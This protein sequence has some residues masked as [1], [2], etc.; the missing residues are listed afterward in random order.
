M[1][2]SF[3]RAALYITLISLVLTGCGDSINSANETPATATVVAVAAEPT[4]VPTPTEAVPT[5]T[6]EPTQAAP[7]VEPTAEPT[8][9]NTPPPAEPSPTTAPVESEALVRTFHLVP[10]SS[11]ASYSVEE[12]FF[13]QAVNFFN[14][15]GTTQAIEGE[16]TV[17]VERNQVTLGDNRFVVDLRTL[18]SDNSRRDNRIREQWLESNTYPLAEFV[19]TGLEGFPENVAEGQDISFK[20][21]GD[22]T[23]REVTRPLTFNT[24]ARLEGNTI[25]GAATTQLLMRDFGFEPPSILGMLEV[26]DGVTV[27]VEFT[28]VEDNNPS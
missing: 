23:I 26:T 19:A 27:T 24:T 28:A 4:Q 22:M 17:N 2:T 14:A 5:A 12:E 16:F 11:K 21:V 18:A 8:Q 7:I 13:N 1:L 3:I 10:E 25:T 15:V 9:T 20:V 6:A